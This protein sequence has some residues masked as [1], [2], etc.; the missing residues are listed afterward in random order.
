MQIED[1]Q[2]FRKQMQAEVS[3]SDNKAEKKLHGKGHDLRSKE[4][5]KGPCFHQYTPLNAHRAKILEEAL[6]TKL[7]SIP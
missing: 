6:S 5:T 7:M 4:S 2:D 3:S 1:M